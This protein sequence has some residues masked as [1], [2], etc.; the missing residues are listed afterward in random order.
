MVRHDST[1][2]RMARR[3]PERERECLVYLHVFASVMP[4]LLRDEDWR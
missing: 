1:Q 2:S 4:Q 3:R